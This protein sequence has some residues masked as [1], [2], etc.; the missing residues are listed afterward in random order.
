MNLYKYS[1]IIYMGMIGYLSTIPK[2]IKLIDTNWNKTGFLEHSIAFLVLYL[3][4]R[5]S[6]KSMRMYTIIF[7]L[8]LFAILIEV[9]QYFIKSRSSNILDIVAD[10]FGV[11]CI[12]IVLLVF[13]KYYKKY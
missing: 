5:G 6:F 7:L 1:L 10:M 2:G 9:I 8:F 4:M 11:I 3:L 13:E 12:I